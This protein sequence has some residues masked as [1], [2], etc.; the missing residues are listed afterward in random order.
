ML[1]GWNTCFEDDPKRRPYRGGLQMYSPVRRREAVGRSQFEEM[2]SACG[3]E[4][5][6]EADHLWNILRR[7][8]SK[9]PKQIKLSSI[10][11]RIR[12]GAAPDEACD[13]QEAR[14]TVSTVHRA[15]GLEF[16][17]VLL[18]Y[19]ERSRPR[20]TNCPKKRGCCTSA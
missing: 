5:P 15:K 11:E 16:N 14:I 12:S 4:L 3:L 13:S 2:V 6:A 10:S 7:L 9:E 19:P 17:E 8:D 18:V 20:M 1:L